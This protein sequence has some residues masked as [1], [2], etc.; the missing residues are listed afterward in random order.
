MAIIQ[1]LFEEGVAD[2]AC[3]KCSAQIDIFQVVHL[4]ICFG[5]RAGLIGKVERLRGYQFLQVFLESSSI[6]FVW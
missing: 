1:P 5:R 6:L 2:D 4:D 3:V